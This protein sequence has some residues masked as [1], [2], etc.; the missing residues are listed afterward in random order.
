MS[1]RLGFLLGALLLLAPLAGCLGGEDVDEPVEGQTDTSA[2]STPP[3]P[4][5]GGAQ[6][7]VEEALPGELP[8]WIHGDHWTYDIRLDLGFGEL[9]SGDTTVVVHDTTNGYGLA[10]A[11]RGAG[12]VDAH[13]DTFFVGRVDTNLNPQDQTSFQMFDFPL[14]DGKTWST[15]MPFA[16]E[17]VTLTA[18]A[19]DDAGDPLGA[20]PGFLISGA[21]DSGWSL[22]YVFSPLSKWVTTFTLTGSA[23]G[24]EPREVLTMTLKDHAPNFLGSFVLITMEPLY[25][26]F[27]IPVFP[28]PELM[29]VPP[30]DTITVP[31][32]FT[33][34]QRFVGIFGFDLNEA[35]T[36][37]A[38]QVDIFDPEMGHNSYQQ[39]GSG[40]T[41]DLA[42]YEPPITG[43]WHV[44]YTGAGTVGIFVGFWGYHEEVVE[45][46][47]AS[48]AHHA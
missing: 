34:T 28:D 8:T 16:G 37:G 14:E 13:F 48:H 29:A 41:T 19:A 4:G 17:S 27:V 15:N 47:Q 9:L 26:R 40:S 42:Q 5:A 20:T 36:A 33:F 38:A 39:V 21:T 44:S 43:D 7:V 31:D 45:F 11:D 35:P 12:M 23:F 24:E 30:A 25:E 32:G 10:A 2:V 6:G 1:T 3:L 22:E 46:T 18:T